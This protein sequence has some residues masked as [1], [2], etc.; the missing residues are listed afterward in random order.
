MHAQSVVGLP[1]FAEHGCCV[2]CYEEQIV[3]NQLYTQP[4]VAFKSTLAK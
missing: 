3:V 1:T 4:Q 2:T